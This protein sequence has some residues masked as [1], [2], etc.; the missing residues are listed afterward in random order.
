MKPEPSL[1]L[2]TKAA[3]MDSLFLVRIQTAY[4]ETVSVITGVHSRPTS[5]HG[6]NQRGYTSAHLPY[7]L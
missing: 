2:N 6:K 4:S 1:A 7:M 3:R 5:A